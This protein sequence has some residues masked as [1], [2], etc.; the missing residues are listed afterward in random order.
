MDAMKRALSMLSSVFVLAAGC[1]VSHAATPV[2]TTAP[3]PLPPIGPSADPEY[4]RLLARINEFS[5]AISR[6]TKAAELRRY[7]FGQ[8]EVVMELAGRSK[9]ME[10]DDWIRMGID[11]YQ[12]AALLS[13]GNEL[14]ARQRLVQ[15][16]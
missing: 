16:P 11:S 1:V 8:G 3:S 4:E 13:P 14:S 15:I 12:S 2:A 7:Q 6:S 9:G 10:R 5:D